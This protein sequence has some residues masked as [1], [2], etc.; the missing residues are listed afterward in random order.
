MNKIINNMIYVLAVILGILILIFK[1]NLANII[2]IVS[3]FSFLIGALLIIVKNLYGYLLSGIGL[4]TII[5]TILYRMKIL[6][7]NDTITFTLSLSLIMTI[8]MAY[9]IEFIK[10]KKNMKI[11][12]LITEGEV[13]DI[14]RVPNVK[15][16]VY[17]PIY[18][19]EVDGELFDV[20]YL[21]IFKRK[22]PEI[23][24]KKTI[25]VNPYDHLDVYFEQTKK[26]KLFIICCYL[27]LIIVS[28]YIIVGLF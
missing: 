12:S 13:I 8:T 28:I 16:E 23:G 21:R 14:V 5:G 10:D 15:K 11:H 1:D 19:Y 18:R 7:L 4:S 3:I 2:L 27:F 6:E 24:D 17:Y 26:D 22:V 20:D 9:V 25:R